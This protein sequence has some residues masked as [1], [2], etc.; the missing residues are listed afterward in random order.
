[1]RLDGV[2]G[3][4]VQLATKGAAR[5]AWPLDPSVTHLNHGSF[6]APPRE[7]LRYQRE[8]RAQAERS[9]VGWFAGLEH[10]VRAARE[11]LAPFLGARADDVALVPNASAAATVVFNALRL[12]PGD[13]IVVTDHGYGAVT[14]GAQ[15]LARRWQASVR[16][17]S[18]PLLADEDEV[19]GAFQTELGPRT[20]LVIVDQIT[21]PTAC[22]LPVPRI[23]ALAHARGARVLVDGAHAPGL[24]DAPVAAAG[25]DWWFGNFH[26]WTCAPHSA[27]ALV[28][29]AADRDEL[30]P[31][32]DS[33]GAAEPYPQRFDSQGTV[34]VTS[35]LSA[36]YAIDFIER[37]YGWAHARETMTGL[38]SEGARA[39]ATALQPHLDEEALV[40]SPTPA[41]AMRLVRLPRGLAR[42]TVEANALRALLLETTQIETAITSFAGQGYLRLSAHLYTEPADFD[43]FIERGIPQLL[44]HAR[45]HALATN[46]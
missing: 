1:M 31:P 11:E 13:E 44:H 24:V 9:P 3:T 10:R 25:G 15:R 6:G 35:Y 21:S 26:K 42:S 43:A 4:A 20:R 22:V 40:L 29:A 19:I 33:W 16:T 18:I 39:I 27:A 28:T 36:P 12:D 45:E 23:A 7:V 14:M 17:V 30:W 41:P 46:A 32:I 34:D 8:L 2:D 37:E 38:V 5:E